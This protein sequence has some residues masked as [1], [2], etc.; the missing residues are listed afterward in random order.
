MILFSG[1]TDINRHICN[2]ISTCSEKSVHVICM[3]VCVYERV[4]EENYIFMRERII[5]QMW[6]N[7]N[8]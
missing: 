4:R 3:C 5:K 8:I 7:A 1:N 6:Q 2:P